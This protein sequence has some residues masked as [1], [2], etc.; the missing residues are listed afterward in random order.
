VLYFQD[1]HHFQFLRSG[2]RATRVIVRETLR[3]TWRH[4]L[5]PAPLL[6]IA[7]SAHIARAA[8]R[9]YGAPVLIPNGVDV[10]FGWSGED[11]AIVV[12]GGRG[13]RKSEDV[14]LRAWAAVPPS[15]RGTT[16]LEL[17]GVEPQARRGSLAEL[18]SALGLEG[19]V[20]IR[21]SVPREELLA[22][23]ARARVAVSC[24]RL[25]S[26]GLPVAEALAMGA[27]VVCSDIP[28]HV[29]LLERADAGRAVTTGDPEALAA[30]L[31]EALSGR[32]PARL[33]AAPEGWSWKARAREQVDAF[34]GALDGVASDGDAKP[35]V[36][37]GAD[38]HV[39][40]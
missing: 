3:S 26:F 10:S 19:S 6:G 15:A 8:A 23:I 32:L 5:A 40:H 12:M 35:V 16:T 39:R 18:A 9:R 27:P 28:A 13:T 14:A 25:E 21:G 29:E 24:S 36:T 33:T 17:L 22:R 11:D 30:A 34:R 20:R 37:P 31:T 38:V 4:T 7:V 2:V 1:L